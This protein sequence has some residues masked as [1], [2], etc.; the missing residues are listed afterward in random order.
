PLENILRPTF[1]CTT[2]WSTAAFTLR[3]SPAS[4]GG[5]RIHPSGA[6]RTVPSAAR[7]LFGSGPGLN[8]VI[9]S[10]FKSDLRIDVRPDHRRRPLPRPHGPGASPPSSGGDVPLE[11]AQPDVRRES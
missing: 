3:V 10:A 4:P 2:Q 6:G 8:V 1:S 9:S 7:T 11:I 5:S